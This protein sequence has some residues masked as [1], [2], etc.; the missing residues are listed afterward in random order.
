MKK[1]T[2]LFIFC[3]LLILSA[4][5]KDDAVMTVDPSALANPLTYKSTHTELLLWVSGE[6]MNTE[7]L[8]P[9][10][11]L[12]EDFEHSY[13]FNQ[14]IY[15]FYPDSVKIQT[16]DTTGRHSYRFSN[17]SLYITVENPFYELA[18]PPYLEIYIGMG[19]PYAFQ[20]EFCNAYWDL[21]SSG[22]GK[23][24]FGN[25]TFETI[26]EDYLFSGPP[27]FYSDPS[28]MSEGDTVMIYNQKYFFN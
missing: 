26:D 21:N 20:L 15:T 25:Y 13:P 1:L 23:N 7:G 18:G 27:G 12:P 14:T 4:C 11:I 19:S 2:T 6:Q 10:D 24:I 16:P 8:S 17:D 22:G 3:L 28:E 9:N 5:T